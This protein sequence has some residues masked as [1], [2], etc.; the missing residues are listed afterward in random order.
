[1]GC[2]SESYRDWRCDVAGGERMGIAADITIILVA[3][4]IGGFAA[5]R[6]GQPLIIG[7][8]LAGIAV[9]PFTEYVWVISRPDAV[10]LP[11]DAIDS[12][13]SDWSSFN[14]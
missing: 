13:P 12:S 3:A 1:M 9:G 10:S 2:D 11:V 5:Q 6:L 4:L 8:I 7:Y 14:A